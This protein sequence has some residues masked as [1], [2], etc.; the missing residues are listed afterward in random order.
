MSSAWPERDRALGLLAAAGA[1]ALVALGLT[2]AP[3]LSLP[4]GIAALYLTTKLW[5]RQAGF[6]AALA[7]SAAMLLIPSVRVWLLARHEAFVTPWLLGVPLFLAVFWHLVSVY[8]E[9]F[10]S[11]AAL[12]RALR[13]DPLTELMLYPAFCDLAENEI[14]RLV[15]DGRHFSLVALDLDDF[16]AFNAAYGDKAGD[17]LLRNVVHSIKQGI[18]MLDTLARLGPDEFVLLL[19]ETDQ[20]GARRVLERIAHNALRR[21]ANNGWQITFNACALTCL[22]PPPGVPELLTL[23]HTLMHDSK[24][25]G[26]GQVV[27]HE[28][29]GR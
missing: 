21:A 15:R 1:A 22:A 11:R 29:A 17:E 16:A 10:E 3:A 18:R 2:P 4:F 23:L 12:E 6:R 27:F 9:L 7:A 25:E 24:Q 14:A 19:P 13:R 28:Y 8:D 20:P 26:P 5:G